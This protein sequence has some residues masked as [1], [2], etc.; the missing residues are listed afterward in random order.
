[1]TRRLA[2]AAALCALMAACG[3]KT[4]A[5]QAPAA[6]V[7]PAARPATPSAPARAATPPAPQAPAAAPE[8]PAAPRAAEGPA[9]PPLSASDEKLA[10]GQFYD[11]YPLPVE[12]GHGTVITVHSKGFEPVIVLLDAKRQKVVEARG[13]ADGGGAW[14]VTLVDVFPAG[15][16][17]VL[18]AAADVGATGAY[19]IEAQSSTPID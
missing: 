15:N 9:R 13:H 5:P 10:T 3:P 11:A 16:Y 2:T 1:M 18:V 4:P 19:T 17:F 14:T 8:A 12:A 7:A 6:P